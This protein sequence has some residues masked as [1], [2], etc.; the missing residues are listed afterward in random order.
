MRSDLVFGALAHVSSRYRLC[1]IATDATRKFHRPHT[2]LQET[3]NNV[4]LR[5]RECDPEAEH[6]KQM[7]VG[8]SVEARFILPAVPQGALQN[9]SRDG[10]K[11]RQF[12]PLHPEFRQP[13]PDL[14]A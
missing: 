4:L 12:T 6:S 1:K 10:F 8:D 7:S 13:Q 3:I 2:R 5:F 9:A 11:T 14:E